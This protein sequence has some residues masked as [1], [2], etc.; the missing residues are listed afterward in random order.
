MATNF[1][2]SP[3]VDDTFTSSGVTYKWDGTVWKA[4]GSGEFVATVTTGDTAPT[5]P[6]NGDLWYRTSD[7]RT[8]LYYD[9]SSSQQWVD[10]SPSLVADSDTFQRSGTTVSL[11]NSGDTVSLDGDLT[12]DTDTLHVDSASNL[13]GIGTDSP[14]NLLDVRGDSS[15]QIKVSATNTGTNSAGL[16]IENQ[17][18]RNWQIWADR[19]TDTFRIGNNSRTDTDIT[20]DSSGNFIFGTATPAQIVAGT[21]SG[22]YVQGSDVNFISCRATSSSATHQSFINSNGTVGSISTGGSSTNYNTSSDYRLKENVVELDGA[23]DR[24]KQLA[25][26]RF[27]FITDADTT[28]D[29]FLAHEA[30]AVVPEAVTGS[31]DEVDGDGNAVTQGIDQSKLVPLL[32]AALQ[33]AITKIETLEQRLTDAGL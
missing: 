26:K 2:A 28:V 25:P 29:G 32:T 8:Y 5:S 23:I 10:V 30:Q 9:D 16:F 7:N 4:T 22:K 12:V 11:V 1:P 27:N 18:Q 15:P 19:A 31:K 21:A 33:E 3:S 20:L 6:Q 14:D 13:V 24:V 17:G